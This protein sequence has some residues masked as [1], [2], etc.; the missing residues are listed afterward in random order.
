MQLP[1]RPQPQAQ[2]QDEPTD[3]LRADQSVAAPTGAVPVDQGQVD[4]V[5]EI[6]IAW[7]SNPVP[8]NQLVRM[9]PQYPDGTIVQGGGYGLA[10]APPPQIGYYDPATNSYGA[11]PPDRFPRELWGLIKIF[12]LG[13][14]G[15]GLAWMLL[16]VLNNSPNAMLGAITNKAIETP[17]T[18]NLSIDCGGFLTQC[19][20]IPRDLLANATAP[21]TTT[22]QNTPTGVTVQ[23]TVSQPATAAPPMPQ[24]QQFV[25]IQPNTELMDQQGNVIRQISAGESV[26]LTGLGGVNDKGMKFQE[27]VVQS[28]QGTTQQGW[29][30]DGQIIR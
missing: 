5:P 24:V 2:P 19:P 10:V 12:L 27:V 7:E 28:P 26:G 20:E 22:V 4:E 23:S 8:A 29:I 17:R 15:L 18:I 30:L 6:A 16:R 21:G 3:Q 1:I 14:F 11:P 25:Q 13:C 9:A